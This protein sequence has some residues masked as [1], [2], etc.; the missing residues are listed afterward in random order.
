MQSL[1][2]DPQAA[3]RLRQSLQGGFPEKLIALTCLTDLRIRRAGQL[4]FTSPIDT[5]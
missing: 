4:T 5:M 2:F 1:E 3:A